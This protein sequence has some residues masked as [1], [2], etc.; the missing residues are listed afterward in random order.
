MTSLAE[1]LP[2]EINRV[3]EIQNHFKELRSMPNVIVE[4][5]I[6][7]MEASITRAIT[8]ASSGDVIE[9]MRCYEDLKGYNE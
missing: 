2:K 3:R 4:P 9:M 7:M 6:T 8:A 1:E 5:Q